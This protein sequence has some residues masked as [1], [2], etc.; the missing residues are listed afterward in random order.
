MVGPLGRPDTAD[1][2][3][4]VAAYPEVKPQLTGPGGECGG[5]FD[6][7]GDLIE[8]NVVLL[9][10][11]IEAYEAEQQRRCDAVPQCRTDGDVRAAYV[12]VLENLSPDLIH[13]NVL[14]QAAGGRPHLARRRR[15]P[16]AR[17]RLRLSPC[18]QPKSKAD[19]SKIPT[20]DTTGVG[21]GSRTGLVWGS[22][23][24]RGLVVDG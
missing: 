19:T 17:G 9:T 14:G 22:C 11:R 3:E 15:H 7:S 4:L 18:H 16:R 12:D 6:I 10:N 1:F 23:H 20:I 8:E 5:F 21:P 13:L 24:R 2:E